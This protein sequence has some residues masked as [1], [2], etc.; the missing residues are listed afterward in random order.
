MNK[1]NLAS[2]I[3]SVI[4]MVLVVI[5]Y[6]VSIRQI[7]QIHAER[8]YH[9]VIE[10]KKIDIKESVENQ[11]I[12]IENYQQSY[13]ANLTAIHED[14]MS[15]TFAH[16]PTEAELIDHVNHI[17]T[18]I[19]DA[20]I[21]LIENNDTIL[22]NPNGYTG[23]IDD[24]ILD[25]QFSSSKT[26]TYDSYTIF[27][28]NRQSFIDERIFN[29]VKQD[30]MNAE[31]ELHTY[32]WINQILDYDGGDDYAVRFIHPNS[33]P[34]SG[35]LLSTNTVVYGKQPYLEELEGI[36]ANG[37]IYLEYHFKLP[38]SEELGQKIAFAK[39]YPKYDW[40]VAMGVYIEDI[41]Y[42]VNLERD[43]SLNQ[44]IQISVVFI[45]VFA[46]VYS[47]N[48][49]GIILTNRIQN[50]LILNS[51]IEQS[52]KDELTGAYLRRVTINHYD[53]YLEAVKKNPEKKIM[54]A[55][56]DIDHFKQINDTYG[57]EMGDHILN[58]LVTYLHSKDFVQHKVY[59]WGGDEFILIIEYDE[60]DIESCLK[61]LVVEIQALS[62]S[63]NDNQAT[64]TIS[65]GLTS[66]TEND[67]T[68]DSVVTRAD[69]GLYLSKKQ[70]RNR[71][72]K[73]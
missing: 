55:L 8:I 33:N 66:I 1:Y 53:N 56:F 49:Y 12:R 30:I 64:I 63:H 52:N 32:M 41:Q 44:T 6:A 62:F 46:F 50:S 43:S 24:A 40:V 47:I 51:T 7:N 26:Y 71:L 3:S 37:E 14:Y 59:R 15:H 11:I 10:Q 16:L 23:S 4:A 73:I 72:T 31:Y 48:Y 38:N 21:V 17:N 28:G 69:K 20:F 35:T 68:I 36:K 2:L 27:I 19:L 25:D 9:S 70:G 5:L 57:H 60:C 61:D 13:D 39:L 22:H 65:M 18:L 42:Y 67:T 34:T 58:R 29:Q 45:L 54:L